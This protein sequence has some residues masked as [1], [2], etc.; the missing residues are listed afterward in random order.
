MA[1]PPCGT[2]CVPERG[3]MVSVPAP[4]VHHVAHTSVAAG[5]DCCGCTSDVPAAAQQQCADMHLRLWRC[6]RV[7]ARPPAA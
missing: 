6:R 5:R 7:A 3:A 2:M 4:A 1:R